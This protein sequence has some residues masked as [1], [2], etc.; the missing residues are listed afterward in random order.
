MITGERGHSRRGNEEKKRIMGDKGWEAY[1]HCAVK[2]PP[3]IL[4]SLSVFWIL[5]FI[6]IFPYCYR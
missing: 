4:H 1:G 6:V 3:P 2:L 5:K